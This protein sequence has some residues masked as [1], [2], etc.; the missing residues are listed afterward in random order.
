LGDNYGG[1]FDGA[2]FDL[3]VAGVVEFLI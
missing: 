1:G 3:A 2:A